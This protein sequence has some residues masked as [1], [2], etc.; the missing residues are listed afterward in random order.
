MTAGMPVRQDRIL[1]YVTAFC[2]HCHDD[3]PARPLELV[4]RLSGYLSEVEGRVWLVRG[5]PHHGKVVTLY[6]ENPQIL[7]YLEQWTVPTKAH[8]PDVRG[9]YDPIPAAYLRGLGEMQTQHTCILLEDINENCNLNCPTCF[10]SSSPRLTGVAEVASIMANI[11]QRL[12]REGGRIDVLMLSGGEPTIHPEFATILEAAIERN[13]VRVLVNTNGVLVA[14]DDDLLAL[15][16]RHRDRV[17][18]Y[19]QFDGFD[20][21]THLHHR[22]ADLRSI[23]QR[24]VRRLS[25][26]GVFTTLTMTAALGVNDHEI[27]AVVMMALETPYVGG[28]SIQPQFGSGRSGP[29]N[30]LERLTHTGVLARLEPQTRGVVDWQ[31]LTALPCSHPHCASVGYMLLDDA[32]EWRSLARVIGHD[33]LKAHLGLVSNRIADPD[34]AADLRDLVKASLLGLLS[35]QASLTHPTVMQLFRDVCE[36]C[37]L[38]LSTLLKMATGSKRRQAAL[39]D[40]VATRIK[41]ITVKP[42][43]DMNTMLEERL[44][45]CCVHVGTR[46]AIQEQCAPFCAVQAW[47][48]LSEMKVSSAAR[49]HTRR[50]IPLHTS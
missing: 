3:D 4:E 13:V 5:C 45:Q 17:E 32:G 37:D 28:V 34:L 7:A 46:S 20:K 2:P 11:D 31:D 24:A 1:R 30:P 38:G 41:R 26:A 43:M 15:L 9:N 16:E 23:K 8:I 47:S 14:R 49:R 6:D 22:A 42:F 12:E 19:L 44:M 40:I 50:T 10:A 33:R 39:R 48:P 25:E 29:I 36:A 35:E 18:V 27:G 21:A